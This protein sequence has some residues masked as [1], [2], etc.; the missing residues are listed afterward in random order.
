MSKTVTSV[1]LDE[2]LAERVSNDDSVNL[3]GTVNMLLREYFQGGRGDLA[4]LEL[5]EEQLQSEVSSLANDLETKRE[6]LA[7]VQERIA[8]VR[9]ERQDQRQSTIEDA[10]EIFDD[11]DR[12]Y[13]DESNPHVQRFAEQLD[14][15]PADLLEAYDER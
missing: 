11:I 14:M 1:S 15:E 2:D 12:P 4:M 9:D 8:A 10:F 5:R 3:S 13:L 7:R 6:E